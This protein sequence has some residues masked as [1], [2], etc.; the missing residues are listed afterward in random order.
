LLYSIDSA[1]VPANTLQAIDAIINPLLSGPDN[2]LIP[3]AEGQR[4]LLTEATGSFDNSAP[5]NPA[6][7]LGDNGQ[8]L[9]ANAND[10]IEFTG[11]RWV[12]SFDSSSSPAN[13]QYVTNITTSIQ[14][15]WTG[16][17]WV[18]SYQGLYPGGKWNII[19]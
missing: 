17:M 18:K 1:T 11:G 3:A 12:V 9:V 13:L 4:Y 19:L 15:Q 7:W 8:P 2:G 5:A 10:I 6:A 14:Y 16:Q